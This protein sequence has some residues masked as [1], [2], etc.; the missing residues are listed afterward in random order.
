MDCAG[1]LENNNTVIQCQNVLDNLLLF[2]SEKE[3]AFEMHH[4]HHGKDDCF[5][6][7]HPAYL[8]S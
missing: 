2:T 6:I 7:A 5:A 8:R 3:R 4:C 1:V